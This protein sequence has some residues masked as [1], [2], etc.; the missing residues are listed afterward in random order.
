MLSL[1]ILFLSAAATR[2]GVMTAF[3]S[4]DMAWGSGGIRGTD[5]RRSMVS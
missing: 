2:H 4:G 5:A 1:I 3:Y